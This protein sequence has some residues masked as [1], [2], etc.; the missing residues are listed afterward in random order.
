MNQ[1]Q[2]DEILRKHALYLKNDQIEYRADLTGAN[3]SYTNLR[4]T[5]L[6]NAD[7]RNAELRNAELRN[8]D[9]RNADLRNAE[10]RNAELRN[11]DL[12][13]A[14]L[15]NADLSYSD[16]R[17]ADLRNAEL[18]NA[19]LSN[20][21]LSGVRNLLSASNWIRNNFKTT[22]NGVIVY[23]R[24][25]AI[26]TEYSKPDHWNVETNCYLTETCNPDRT[27]PCACGVNFGTKDWCSNH[28]QYCD[29]WECLIEWIDLA[30]VVVPYNTDGKARCERLLLLEKI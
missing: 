6:R 19:D 3:L 16:L 8:A 13:N 26:K 7:L 27:T 5:D 25:G 28:Y 2:L 18:R 14:E 22:K 23:K 20:A 9:L 30:G 17:Y 10:L 29:L 24:I 15:R 21:N 11:A 4:S 1:N 12:R